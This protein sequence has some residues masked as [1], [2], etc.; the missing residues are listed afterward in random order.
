MRIRDLVVS[1][2]VIVLTPSL[3]RASLDEIDIV[4]LFSN[5]CGT[6]QFVEINIAGR[7]GNVNG[8]QLRI[9]NHTGALTRTLTFSS[10]VA[11]TSRFLLATANFAQVAGV[12]ADTQLGTL[13][14]N[15]LD[16]AGG[17]L[18]FGCCGI[19]QDADTIVYGNYTGPMPP[20]GTTIVHAST[21]LPLPSDG[22]SLI[23][24]GS[25]FTPAFN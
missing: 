10:D 13:N 16:R 3:A 8:R 21:P 20:A 5:S 22:R 12:T 1:L 23:R 11:S 19:D 6:T 2:S 25:S 18:W 14:A 4:E 9:F 7:N 15:D 17:A 24:N